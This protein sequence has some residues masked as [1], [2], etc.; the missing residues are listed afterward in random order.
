MNA[1]F[2]KKA[3]IVFHA[4][5][6]A[7]SGCGQRINGPCVK[8][9]H[10]LRR[11]LQTESGDHVLEAAGDTPTVELTAAPHFLKNQTK[12]R[13]HGRKKK[14]KGRRLPAFLEDLEQEF[15]FGETRRG[16]FRRWFRH[17]TLNLKMLSDIIWRRWLQL[18]CF[19]YLHWNH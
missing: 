2:V 7:V 16:K 1:P 4:D 10:C 14:M 17:Q 6:A 19:L 5:D 11:W 3:R 12:G 18:Q 8:A 9:N 13:Q 15:G